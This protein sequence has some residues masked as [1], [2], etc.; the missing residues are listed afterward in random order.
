MAAGNSCTTV[1]AAADHLRGRFGDS[2]AA[3]MAYGSRVFGQARSGS[4]YDFWLIVRDLEAFHHENADFYRERL[5]IRSTPEEQIALNRSGPLFYS[6]QENGVRIKLAVLGEPEFVELCSDEWWTVKGRVQKPLRVFFSTPRVDEAVV[7]ARRD[8][9]AAA[10][11]LLP[12]TFTLDAMLHELVALSYRAEVRPERKNAKVHSIVV[13]ARAELDAI[14]V[15]LL[16]E[17]PYVECHGGGYRDLRHEEDR[18]R[19][20]AATVRSLRRSKWCKRSLGFIWR[21]YRSHRGPVRYILR[22]IC[23]E[24]EKTVRRSG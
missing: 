20:R 18:A 5:N 8:G 9:V 17:L 22:K 24:V 14:Y 1:E 12:A 7:A 6:L 10:L 4:A 13:T 23:G 11:N 16:D 21:N 3:L 2:L 15:P 19:A